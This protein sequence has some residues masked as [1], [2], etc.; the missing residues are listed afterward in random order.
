MSRTETD[1]T[2]DLIAEFGENA[3][4]VAD[5]L[6]RFRANPEAV[7]EE[8]RE[9]FRE[10]LGEPPVAGG[11]RR[12]AKRLPPPDALGRLPQAGPRRVPRGLPPPSRPR[13]RASCARARSA[14]PSEERLC[15]SPRTWRR[16]SRCPPRPR[17]GRSRSSSSTRTAGSS[18][19]GG[20][21]TSRER[22]P[23]RI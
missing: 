4:Y 16:A 12:Q 17:S 7:D 9:F 23:L 10:R 18:M 5:L 19:D 1:L 2:E 3:T 11:G 14:T 13:R 15:A 6:A 8:W 22:S 20:R 21:T